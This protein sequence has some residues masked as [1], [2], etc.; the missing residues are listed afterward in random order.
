MSQKI[1]KN[2]LL[3]EMNCE[4][5]GFGRRLNKIGCMYIILKSQSLWYQ[6][7]DYKN[8]KFKYYVDFFYKKKPT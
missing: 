6:D 4:H 3:K 1:E 5:W 7:R 2:K 8:N